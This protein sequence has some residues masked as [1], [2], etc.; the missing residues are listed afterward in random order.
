MRIVTTFRPALGMALLALALGACGTSHRTAAGPATP[1]GVR[2]R[3]FRILLSPAL[4]PAGRVRLT[5]DDVGPA[6][7]ELILV[8]ARPGG[9]PIRADGLTVDEDALA[10]VTVG[11]LE[12]A[13][14]GTVRHLE[15]T[16][17]KGRYVLFCNMAGHYLGGMRAILVVT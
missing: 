12:P 6:D 1:V 17:R 15:V 16:L 7:H 2:E 8:R 11:A 13:R 5:V 14:P 4:V 9:L 3:D 10:P